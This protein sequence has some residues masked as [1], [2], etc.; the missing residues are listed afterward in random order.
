MK[1]MGSIYVAFRK[2]RAKQ[3]KVK[4]HCQSYVGA[5]TGTV[6]DVGLS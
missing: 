2:G 6:T 1:S 4:V 3:I 5:E